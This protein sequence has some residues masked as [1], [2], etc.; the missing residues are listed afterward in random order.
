MTPK[1][2]TFYKVIRVIR[3]CETDE[4]LD[5]AKR[6]AVQYLRQHYG[7]RRAYVERYWDDLSIL[8]NEFKRV[9]NKIESHQIIYYEPVNNGGMLK[10]QKP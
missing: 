5:V 2:A 4:H 9:A 3:S 8:N 6:Y 7:P 10:C 1:K